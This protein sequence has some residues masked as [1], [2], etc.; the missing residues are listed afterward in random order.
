MDGDVRPH[1]RTLRIRRIPTWSVLPNAPRPGSP[2]GIDLLDGRFR[3]WSPPHGDVGLGVQTALWNLHIV[4]MG[5]RSLIC[6]FPHGSGQPGHVDH[7]A[8]DHQFAE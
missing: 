4:G 7:A 6:P 2:F 3:N 1:H 8:V 5:R